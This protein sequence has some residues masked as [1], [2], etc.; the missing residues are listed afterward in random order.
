LLY[1]GDAVGHPIHLE[2]PDWN[3]ATDVVPDQAITARRELLDRAAI[4]KAL[5]LA[6][7]FP[8]PGLGYVVPKGAAWAWQPFETGS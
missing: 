1:L 8:F 7:H 6:F 3:I 5:V 4:D 2:H